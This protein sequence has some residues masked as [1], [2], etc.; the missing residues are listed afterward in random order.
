M[1]VSM[2]NRGVEFNISADVVK[3][4]DLTWNVGFNATYNKNEIT[5]LTIFKQS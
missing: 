5:K 2:E 3:T 4:K 1:L